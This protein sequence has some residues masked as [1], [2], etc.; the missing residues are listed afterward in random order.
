V[1]QALLAALALVIALATATRADGIQEWQ[2]PDGILYFGTKPPPGSTLV[3]TV[4]FDETGEPA[5]EE[6]ATAID[7]AVARAAA[8]GREIIRRRA[9]ERQD[10]KRRQHER[11][12]RELAAAAAQPDIVVIHET[13]P[14]FPRRRCHPFRPDA[15]RPPLPAIVPPAAA[16]RPPAAGRL[17]S[18]GSIREAL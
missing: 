6:P 11:L 3:K 2:T 7:D 13:V 4:D 14:F 18:R 9:A 17:A 10:E 12:E 1:P 5:G 15:P 8:D 16:P